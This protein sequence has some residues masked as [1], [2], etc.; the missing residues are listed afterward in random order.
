MVTSPGARYSY[1]DY[2]PIIKV[3]VGN[4]AESDHGPDASSLRSS[5][6][7]TALYSLAQTP[8]RAL[9]R[10]SVGEAGSMLSSA[11]ATA[12]RP[13][14]PWWGS[15]PLRTLEAQ[16]GLGLARAAGTQGGVSVRR[17]AEG[18]TCHSPVLLPPRPCAP[19]S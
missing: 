10:V 18:R 2:L 4:S 19:R 7:A 14:A 9:L 3:A 15:A 13:L 16:R 5:L 1:C 12:P 17:L 8:T 6:A 11:Q